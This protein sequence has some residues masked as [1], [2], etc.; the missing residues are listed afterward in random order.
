MKLEVE[1]Q[2]I[3]EAFLF[4]KNKMEK[5]FVTYEQALALK[6]L[7]L[8]K[9]GVENIGHTF[10]FYASFYTTATPTLEIEWDNE[11]DAFEIII[12]APLKQQVFDFFREKYKI[13]NPQKLIFPTIGGTWGLKSWDE[14]DQSDGYFN[15]YEEA[16]NVLIDKLIEIVKK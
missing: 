1:S 5:E 12:F 7:A 6:E 15:T 9:L 10:G 8:K 14:H 4:K 3:Y 13:I 11:Y 16:E 2:W